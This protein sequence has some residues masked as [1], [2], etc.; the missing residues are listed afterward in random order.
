MG[1]LKLHAIYTALKIIVNLRSRELKLHVI[2]TALKIIVN[3]QSREW[4]N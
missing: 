1:E 3:L 2:Y 4:E